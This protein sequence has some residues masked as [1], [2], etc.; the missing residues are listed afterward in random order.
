M[1]QRV[2]F[3]DF[4]ADMGKF[5]LKSVLPLF[6]RY[7]ELLVETN[8]R[9][10][11]VS[12]ATSLDDYWTKHYLDSITPARF[13]DFHNERILDFGT[14]GGLPGIPLRILYPTCRMELLDSRKK[15]CD[16]VGE[17][18]ENLGLTNARTISSRLEELDMRRF[19]GR[20]DTIVCRSVKIEPRF[21]S[22]LKKLVKRGGRLLFYKAKE[23]DDLKP[24]AGIEFLD[25][26]HPAL[27][28]RRIGVWKR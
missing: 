2:Q 26:S 9:I 13:F 6:D 10:N 23:I 11:L 4:M 5:D 22:T 25:V 19:S 17:I 7:H 24:F 18:I 1:N 21:A 20:Y 3:V 8:A 27:G 15:K 14:G 12:R 28:D 16:A